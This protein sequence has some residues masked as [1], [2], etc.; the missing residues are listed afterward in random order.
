M[1]QYS[2]LFFLIIILILAI[3]MII[4]PD[5]TVEAA[6]D[7]LK[8]WALVVVPALLPFFIAAEL[9]F[10]L[11]LVY[12]LGILLEPVIQPLFRLPGSSALV[13]VMGFTSGFP[14]GALLS[15]KLYD[16]ELLTA[17]ETE[18][19][20]SFT[21]NSS[22]LFILGAVGIGMFASREI[23][24]LLAFSHYMAN[25]L[26]GILW[27]FKAI[28]RIKMRSEHI[29][30]R[31]TSMS[32]LK[33]K[34]Q[35]LN[36][37]S[38]MSEAIKNSINNILAIGGFIL[39]FSVI[40]RMLTCWGFMGILAQFLELL[41]SFLGISW[42]GAYGM[43]MG[44]FEMTIGARTIAASDINNLSAQLAAVSIVLAFS[45]FSVI[46]Q[47][48]SIFAGT[49]IRL[50]FYLLSRL[51]QMSFSCII[52]L[53][54][55]KY[56]LLSHAVLPALKIEPYKFLYSFDALTIA[57]YSILSALLLLG[58]LIMAATFSRYD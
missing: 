56:W 1:K 42:Q 4:N 8:L 11:G 20:A 33:D 3:F 54:G 30:N 6:A 19:L 29:N 34:L 41:F 38:V 48:M 49:P 35:N 50:S 25:F 58:I 36:I 22:P 2:G 24:F 9:L 23:G 18:R 12:L 13:V 44:F 52:T 55:Y 32:L 40:T 53:I 14:V 7:G 27:R 45:G 21:N 5:A 10:S 31:H 28:T 51:L 15:R 39:I 17:E 57:C 43:A 26:V 16:E 46:A 47:I 37:G